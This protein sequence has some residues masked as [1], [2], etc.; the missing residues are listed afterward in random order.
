LRIC[1]HVDLSSGG[2]ESH[3]M[4]LPKSE[5]AM[6]STGGIQKLY[7]VTG[8]DIQAVQQGR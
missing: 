3:G 4:S 2:T 8:L 1:S 7:N 5:S 6:M